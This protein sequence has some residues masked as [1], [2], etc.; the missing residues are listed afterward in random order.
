M[1]W[2]PVP[3]TNAASRYTLI[4]SVIV[5]LHTNR[6]LGRYQTFAGHS[7]RL[8]GVDGVSKGLIVVKLN[9]EGRGVLC[10]VVKP[11]GKT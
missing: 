3:I 11:N 7:A 10:R 6:S 1:P 9:G 5:I 8:S 2:R 4:Y